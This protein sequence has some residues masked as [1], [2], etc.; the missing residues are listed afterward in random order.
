MSVIVRREQSIIA[1]SAPENGAQNRSADGSSFEIFL[2][3]PLAV[4]PDALGAELAVVQASIW[5]VSPNISEA[6]NNNTFTFTTGGQTFTE[7]LPDGLY[8]LS[9]IGGYLSTLFV[10]RGLEPN[11]FLFSGQDSTQQAV[12]TMLNAG[13]SITIDDTSLMQ[14]LGWNQPQTL[15]AGV[16]GESFFSDGPAELNRV[17][18][19]LIRSS[20]VP[21]G[22]PVNA[23]SVGVIARIPI[24]L[25]SPPGT[26]INYDPRNAVWC[27]ASS[28]IASPKQSFS[29]DLLDQ[30]LRPTP[31]AGED[32]SLTILIRWSQLFDPEKQKSGLLG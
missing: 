4:P 17:N 29:I 1:S 31:T 23:K 7:T 6:F 32:Y 18:Q 10:N 12:V 14:T 22:I 15:T 8:S 24:G 11:L 20:I 9:A 25:D 19:Y 16:D 3:T 28:L 21:G 27:D 26:Q 5:N 13:D 2:N 30:Q